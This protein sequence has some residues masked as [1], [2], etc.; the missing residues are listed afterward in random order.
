MITACLDSNVIV[1]GIAFRGKPFKVLEHAL[2]RE[3]QLVLTPII[4]E[5]VQR[6]LVGKL[7]LTKNLVD[8][9]LQ[10]LFDVA[11]VY[12]PTQVPEVTQNRGDNVVLETCLMG[13]CDV[14]VTG[15][16]K[17]LLPLSPYKG[18]IIEPPSQFLIRLNKTIQHK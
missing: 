15:D 13:Q 18:L 9:F 1:S 11:S 16:K 12:A 7:G 4:R 17:D 2:A 6:N 8:K 3:F 10:D 14:L 5:E